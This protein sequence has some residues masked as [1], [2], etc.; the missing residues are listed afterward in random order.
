MLE[1]P[2]SLSEE[3]EES[4]ACS[5]SSSEEVV[6]EGAAKDAMRVEGLEPVDD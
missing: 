5:L 1:L 3:V 4:D 2:E 6:R